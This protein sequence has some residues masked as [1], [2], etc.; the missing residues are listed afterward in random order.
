MSW[1]HLMAA[2]L[3]VLAMAAGALAQGAAS[4]VAFYCDFDG[5]LYGREGAANPFVA[6]GNA[7]FVDEGTGQGK[8]LRFGGQDDWPDGRTRMPWEKSSLILD[9]VNLPEDKGVVS[10]KIRWAGARRWA[11]SKRTWLLVLSP[12]VG[13]GLVSPKLQA[14][15]LA[16]VKEADNTLSLFVYQFR[17]ALLNHYF[18]SAKSGASVADP[19]AVALRIPVSDAR[20]GE[21]ALIR[22]GYDRK[23]GKAWLGLNDKIVSASVEFHPGPWHV[24]L[25]GSP[26]TLDERSR[27][28]GFD[29]EIDDLIIDRRAPGDTPAAGTERPSPLPPVAQPPKFGSEAVLLKGDEAG[30]KIERM[31]RGHFDMTLR[32]QGLSGGWAFSVG[33]PSG[34]CFMSTKVTMPYTR[35]FFNGSKD[36]NSAWVAC[37][38]L[39]AYEALGDKKYLAGAERT[40]QALLK[41]QRKEGFWPYAAHYRPETGE[42]ESIYS[43]ATAP[44]E[45]HVQSHPIALLY[46]L[47]RM[48]GKKEYTDAANKGVAFI[49]RGQNA[50]GSWSHHYNFAKKAGESRNGSVGGGEINDDTTTDQM[51]VMLMAYRM[52]GEPAYLA[53]YLRAAEWI[54]SA[55]IDKKAKGWAQ[56]YDANNKPVPARHFEPAA[57]SLSEG[58]ETAPVELMRAYRMT[59]DR[60]YVEPLAKW[61]EW[62]WENRVFSNPEK[63]AWKWHYYYDP[64]D[65]QAF[66]YQDRQRLP[67]DPREMSE[68]GYTA[69]LRQIEKIDQPAPRRAASPETAKAA[70]GAE[71][72][73]IL[74]PEKFRLSTLISSFNWDVGTWIGWENNQG[75]PSGATIQPQSIRGTLLCHSLFLRRMLKGQVPWTHPRAAY[76]AVEWSN[77]FLFVLTPENLYNPLS[78]EE[79]AKAKAAPRL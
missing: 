72:A 49:Y 21:W 9:G 19:N 56:Q 54:L 58:I 23:A 1:R 63:T 20:D 69:I 64:E 78:A 32:Y 15:G 61:R 71:D 8:A 70:I 62:M 65:G 5:T 26:P 31:I 40:G 12:E 41:M 11:D 18:T 28:K 76:D 75:R 33:W 34:L 77:P 47:G 48:T 57:I 36:A 73:A 25:A 17:D 10:L 45:D 60:R 35:Q 46:A 4:P 27:D 3:A 44:Y 39:A 14:T 24:M 59:G 22:V 67:P 30:E 7:T 66:R 16:V 55:F 68:G 50:N 53:S 38:L 51:T 42:Y 37:Q 74:Q 2:G 52:T 6:C 79:I 29:G 13:A 43:D